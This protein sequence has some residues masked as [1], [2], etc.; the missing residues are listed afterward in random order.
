MC[1]DDVHA[2]PTVLDGAAAL[3]ECGEGCGAVIGGS[4][5][6][7]YFHVLDGG[8]T[9]DVEECQALAASTEIEFDGVAVAVERAFEGAFILARHRRDIDVCTKFH[10]LAFVRHT[11]IH[12]LG[13]GVPV[14]SRFDDEVSRD[15]FLHDIRFACLDFRGILEVEVERAVFQTSH[16]TVTC[17]LDVEFL[18]SEAFQWCSFEAFHVERQ[19]QRAPVTVVVN[20]T[21]LEYYIFRFRFTYRRTV[22]LP[23]F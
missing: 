12:I 21:V 22:F 2:A 3:D 14:I 1:R 10:H 6:S 20:E 23:V 16:M 13:K 9:D 19:A 18:H 5:F 7:R 4:D 15:I 17:V 11:V 8:A